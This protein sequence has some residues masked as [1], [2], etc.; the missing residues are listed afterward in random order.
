MSNRSKSITSKRESRS[1]ITHASNR[2]MMKGGANRI[3][4]NYN[5]KGGRRP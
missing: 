5:I 3:Q 2:G 1:F 4:K